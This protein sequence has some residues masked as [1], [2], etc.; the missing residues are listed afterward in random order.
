MIFPPFS[1][2]ILGWFMCKTVPYIQGVS[3]AASVYSLIA[4]SLDRWVVFHRKCRYRGSRVSRK[5]STAR[6][7]HWPESLCQPRPGAHHKKFCIKFA[8]RL[9]KF[10]PPLN[11]WIGVCTKLQLLHPL[12]IR[13]TSPMF[14]LVREEFSLL[15]QKADKSSSSLNL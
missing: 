5:L 3:V 11:L 6:Q 4:V 12:Q 9:K 15:R 1:A 14:G 8:L 10:F 7:T 13:Q 2:W